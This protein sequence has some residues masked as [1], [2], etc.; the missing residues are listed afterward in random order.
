MQSANDFI[1]LNIREYL[2]NE[3]KRL[4]RKFARFSEIDK[5]EQSSN[6][7]VYLIA[8]LG[9]IFNNRVKERMTG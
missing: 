4:E 9:K 5:S 3:D 6:L 2:E 1:V 8:R 7:T